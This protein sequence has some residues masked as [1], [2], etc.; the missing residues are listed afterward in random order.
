M[1]LPPALK[2]KVSA[3]AQA[4]SNYRVAV[5]GAKLEGTVDVYV[6]DFGTISIKPHR[7]MNAGVALILDPA[8]KGKKATL[9]NLHR[10][11]LANTGDNQKWV[12]R[13]EHT[14]RDVEEQGLGRITN[15]Q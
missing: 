5:E 8:R 11:Q 14:L 6:S 13:I 12:M 2:I 7:D 4:T 1:Y 3:W 9:R 15:L 10:E